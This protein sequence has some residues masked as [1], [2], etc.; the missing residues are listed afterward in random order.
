MKNPYT[1]VYATLI[2]NFQGM[3]LAGKVDEIN[4]IYKTRGKIPDTAQPDFFYTQDY[5]AKKTDECCDTF[6]GRNGRSWETNRLSNLTR[7]IND[8]QKND[9]VNG[10]HEIKNFAE[11]LKET[12]EGH[13]YL[14]RKRKIHAGV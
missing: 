6:L 3:G 5:L 4:K 13:Q 8:M 7:I 2:Q 9:P 12:A 1:S 11:A 14:K 10:N